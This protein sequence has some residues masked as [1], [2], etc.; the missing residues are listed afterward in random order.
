MYLALRTRSIILCHAIEKELETRIDRIVT[1]KESTPDRYDLFP[2]RLHL[3]ICSVFNQMPYDLRYL[4]NQ[5]EQSSPYTVFHRATRNK[6][7]VSKRNDS[8]PRVNDNL[9]LIYD[10]LAST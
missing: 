2:C 10:S 5:F 8:I 4:C 1:E 9:I 3:A 6:R 7:E